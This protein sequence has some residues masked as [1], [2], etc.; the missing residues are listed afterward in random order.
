MKMTEPDYSGWSTA[1]ELD[2]ND[3]GITMKRWLRALLFLLLIGIAVT[4]ITSP[5][6]T[7][8]RKP[9]AVIGRDFW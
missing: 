2:P 9:I 5:K 7:A 1:L 8:E 4:L 3:P 6:Q